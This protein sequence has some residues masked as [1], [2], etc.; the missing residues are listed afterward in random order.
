MQTYEALVKQFVLLEDGL[1]VGCNSSKPH[2]KL[3]Y[4]CCCLRVV[5][6]A[7]SNLYFIKKNLIFSAIIPDPFTENL[8]LG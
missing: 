4:A 7:Q 6:Y 8:T 1:T 2:I 5:L 3:M